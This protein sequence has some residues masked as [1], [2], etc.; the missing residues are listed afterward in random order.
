MQDGR[1]NTWDQFIRFMVPKKY[2][3]LIAQCIEP[4]D[5]I[6]LFATMGISGNAWVS[7]GNL[8][9][10]GFPGLEGSIKRDGR[11][12]SW[13]DFLRFMGMEVRENVAEKIRA[14][15]TPTDFLALLG[16]LGIPEDKWRSS[17]W[18]V[19]NKHSSVYKS[20]HNR[21][22]SW[23]N[24]L[25]F[26]GIKISQEEKKNWPTKLASCEEPEEF[27][28]LFRRENIPG[29]TWKNSRWLSENG[30]IALYRALMRDRRFASWKEFRAYMRG[31][32]HESW[33]QKV[34]FCR[35]PQDF[36]KF[37]KE[38]GISVE[39]SRNSSWL[40][41]NGF[42]E[43]F[44]AIMSDRRFGNWST[45]LACLDGFLPMKGIHSE[46]KAFS[47]LRKEILRLRASAEWIV[48]NPKDGEEIRPEEWNEIRKP[49]YY[50]NNIIVKT[51]ADFLAGKVDKK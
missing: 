6:S 17:D 44:N 13:E 33:N 11:W 5:F 48:N 43:V 39:H 15:Q 34:A 16:V 7:S 28:A 29:D 8:R 20:I 22:D 4:N 26:M 25:K 3:K 42:P 40:R 41:K 1:W 10:S 50:E 21:F 27:L 2:A 31:E 14:C 30:H 37:F 49:K 24:F 46:K 36:L 51:V 19:K 38:L 32:E 12:N 23:N 45:F 35:E 9:S 47:L 18:L